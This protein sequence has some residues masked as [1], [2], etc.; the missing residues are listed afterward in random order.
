MHRNTEVI[1]A[2][3]CLM[4]L[5]IAGC[6]RAPDSETSRRFLV[7]QEAFDRASSSEEFLRVAGLYQEILDSGFVCGAL[8]YNQ[9]NAFMRAGQRG[10]AIAA[11]RQAQRY[12]PRDAQLSANLTSAYAGNAPP[13][14]RRPLVE[15]FLFWQDWLSY[16]GKFQM[17]AAGVGLAFAF[18]LLALFTRNHALPRR[19]GWLALALT[20]VLACSAAYDW[21]RF[22]GTEH[23]VVVRGDVVARKGN[24]S[25]YQAA[26][27]EPLSEGT[28]CQVI[29]HRAGWCHIRLGELQEGW[30]EDTDLVVY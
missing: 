21:H 26:F 14:S 20:L 23:G 16:P 2:C 9:G 18:G 7:A 25:S 29:E 27:T 30:V 8:F 1:I 3:L 24:G 15:Y 28:E 17:T 4:L 11:Y 5:A 22:E 13:R 19:L 10:R 6:S 12:L